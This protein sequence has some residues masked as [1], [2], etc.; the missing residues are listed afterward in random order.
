MSLFY[1]VMGN[2]ERVST[3][4]TPWAASFWSIDS[5]GSPI[6]AIDEPASEDS[7]SSKRGAPRNLGEYCLLKRLGAGGMGRVYKAIHRRLEK[8]VA[9]KL[10]PVFKAGDPR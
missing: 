3:R 10:L 7:S 2:Y 1:I 6:D 4:A 5:M 9:I 8:L